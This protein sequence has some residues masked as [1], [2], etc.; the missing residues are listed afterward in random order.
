MPEEAPVIS[1][2]LGFVSFIE[3]LREAAVPDR[4]YKGT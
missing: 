4:S 3:L 1:T 2:T